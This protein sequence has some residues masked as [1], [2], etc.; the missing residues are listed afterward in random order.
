MISNPNKKTYENIE[1]WRSRLFTDNYP[2][3]YVDGVYLKR[4]WGGEIQNVS[5]LVAIGVSSEGFREILGVA[6]GMKEDRE[7]WRSFFAWLKERGL[8]DMD[9]PTRHW[10]RIRT[11]NAIERLNREIKRRTKAVGAFLDG[12][13]ALRL[14]C[15][16]LRHVAGS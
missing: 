9:F 11:N 2:Y 7:S 15:A 1:I 13:S 14:V 8:S 12:R 16:R 3:V 4:N 6:E 10:T 5:I